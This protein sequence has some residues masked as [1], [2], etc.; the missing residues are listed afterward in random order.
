MKATRIL[1]AAIAAFLILQACE[2]QG[3]TL[4]STFTASNTVRLEIDG[5]KV[6]LHDDAD[7]QMAFNARRGEFRAHDDLMQQYFIIV[8]ESMPQKAGDRSN[9]T[10]T[11]TDGGYERVRNNITLE[12][13]SLRGDVMWLC[14]DSRR[15]AAVIRI[16]E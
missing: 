1:P 8:F 11:W 13:K 3:V 14:D 12:A 16:L 2:P 10:I 7:C 6:F 4:L 9:A 15:N 5:A